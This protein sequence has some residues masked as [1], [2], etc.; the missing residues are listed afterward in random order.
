MGIKYTSGNHLPKFTHAIAIIVFSQ[1]LYLIKG[2]LKCKQF[3]WEVQLKEIF[4]L[5]Q[6]PKYLFRHSSRI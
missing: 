3:D 6:F 5:F 2:K 4:L 1:Y